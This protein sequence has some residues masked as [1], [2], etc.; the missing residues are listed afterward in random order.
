[1]ETKP[2]AFTVQMSRTFKRE[3]QTTSDFARELKA[4]TPQDKQDFCDWFNA[5]GQPTE[6]PK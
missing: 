3:G 4:L 5:A 1:M 6:S 2:V